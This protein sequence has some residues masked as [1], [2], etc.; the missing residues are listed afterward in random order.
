M[1]NRSYRCFACAPL[2][3]PVEASRQPGATDSTLPG[4][5]RCNHRHR[6]LLFPGLEGIAWYLHFVGEYQT[7]PSRLEESS[8]L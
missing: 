8:V 5:R 3:I 7:M 4:C 6:T 1:F 2:V